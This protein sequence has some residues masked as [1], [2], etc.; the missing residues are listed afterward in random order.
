MAY[1]GSNPVTLA[2]DSLNHFVVAPPVRWGEGHVAVKRTEQKWEE[3]RG[4]GMKPWG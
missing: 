2:L 4:Y 3:S 1:L